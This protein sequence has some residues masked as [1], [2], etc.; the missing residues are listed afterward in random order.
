MEQIL[1]NLSIN[2]RDA[3]PEGGTIQIETGQTTLSPTEAARNPDARPGQFIWLAVSDT[4]PASARMFCRV[5]LI[6]SSPRRKSAG[7]A[8]DYPPSTASS[9]SIAVG[10]KR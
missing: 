4:G 8:W 6:R 7:T 1:I 2:A 10:L 3:M 5:S 9:A